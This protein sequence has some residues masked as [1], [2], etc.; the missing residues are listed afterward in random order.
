MCCLRQAV[1]VFNLLLAAPVL[2]LALQRQRS[3]IVRLD[4]QRFL[5]LL[6]R[7]RIF[8][9]FKAGAGC[10]QQLGQ[11]S[12]GG[13]HCRAGGEASRISASMWPSA[14]ISPR[15]SPANCRSPSASALVARCKRGRVRSASKNSMGSLRSALTQ[16]VA[17]L[18]RI[19]ET[20]PGLLGHAFVDDPADRVEKWQEFTSEAGGGI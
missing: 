5:Q 14:S 8:L 19:G 11:A 16:R 2:D 13:R 1:P 18:T 4:L 10:V 12:C 9:F 20:V 7:K 15:I 3:G 6:Q 17:E